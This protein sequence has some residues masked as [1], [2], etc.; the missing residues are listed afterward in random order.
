MTKITIDKAALEQALEA[1][2]RQL[3]TDNLDEAAALIEKAHDNLLAAIGQAEKQGSANPEPEWPDTYLKAGW[4]LQDCKICGQAG[5]AMV[6][7]KRKPLSIGAID[8]AIQQHVDPVATYRG[9]H[10]FARAIEAAHGIK[11]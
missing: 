4:T 10:N 2:S 6:S 11:E 9:L 8:D 3:F 1:L 7:P 5:T